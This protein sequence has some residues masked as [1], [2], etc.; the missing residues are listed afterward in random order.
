M[1]RLERSDDG[2]VLRQV[3]S[4]KSVFQLSVAFLYTGQQLGAVDQQIKLLGTLHC[5]SE[6]IVT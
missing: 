6:V 3:K 4:V 2:S 5:T 1:E